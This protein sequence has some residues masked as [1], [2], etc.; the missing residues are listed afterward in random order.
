MIGAE[1]TER[2]ELK[3]EKTEIQGLRC[4]DHVA[5]S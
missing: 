2:T 1:A 3:S 5:C 4:D